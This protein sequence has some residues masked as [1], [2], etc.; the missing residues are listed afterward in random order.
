MNAV[1]AHKDQDALRGLAAWKVRAR[2]AVVGHEHRIAN[3]QGVANDVRHV[4]RGKR[5]LCP[6]VISA[7]FVHISGWLR[8]TT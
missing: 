4:G 6:T 5:Q 8:F 2:R 3:E 7:L 1:V